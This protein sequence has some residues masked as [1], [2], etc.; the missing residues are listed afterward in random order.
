VLFNSYEFLFAFLPIV[1]VGYFAIARLSHFAANAF[2]AGASV[3]FYAWWRLDFVWILAASVVANYLFGHKLSRDATLS[4]TLSQG[5]GRTDRRVLV[6]GIAFNLGLLGYFKYA[7]FFIANVNAVTGADLA[8]LRV[9]LPLGISFFTFTQIAYLVDAWKG[10]AAEYSAVNYLLFVTFFPHLLAGPIIHHKE[11]MPQFA[12]PKLK[13]LDWE[14]LARGLALFA[15]GL[16]KKVLIADPIAPWANAG[17]AHA[18]S[19]TFAD[20]WITMMA[21]VMQ[22]V[23]DFSGYTDMALGA[24]LMLNI[25]LPINFDSPYRSVDIQEFWRR[26]HMT[27]SRFLRDYVYI[28]L[29]GNRGSEARM[30]ALFVVTFAL[31]GFWHGAAWTYVIWGTLHGVALV[32]V[33]LWRKAKRPFPRPVAI[34]IT[35]VFVSAAL[36]IFRAPTLADAGAILASVFGLNGLSLAVTVPQW[37]WIGQ[38][39]VPPGVLAEGTMTLA[40]LVLALV[41]TFTP[42]NS[43]HIAAD[44]ALFAPRL[45]YAFGFLL[46]I[47]LVFVQNATEFIYFIF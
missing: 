7:D 36:V 42:R 45:R 6:A 21:Y 3:F 19:L 22:L 1:I 18:H 26:W 4:P 32:T 34:A 43:N 23:F 13:R 17:F 5:R 38:A 16:G 29:G 2:L 47:S 28:P 44:P 8:L 46:A 15:L 27:L 30:L 12:D 20:G 31:G 9:A 14:N 37:N 24:A 39:G 25:R 11:M 33:H 41:L 40:I 10:K 35:F